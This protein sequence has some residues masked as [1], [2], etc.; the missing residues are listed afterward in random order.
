VGNVALKT[1]EG[2]AKL[3][4]HYMTLEFKKNPLTRLA[5]L[6]ALPVLRSFGRRIDPR[7]YNGAS[8]LGLQGIVIKS[9]GGADSLAFATAIDVAVLEADKALPQQ[10]DRHLNALEAD[11]Q[12]L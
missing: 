9:H 8:L 3:I 6:L 4:R 10:I 7:R 11:R 2:V 5:G 12:A 1:M